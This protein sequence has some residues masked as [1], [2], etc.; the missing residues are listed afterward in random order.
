MRLPL[1][2]TTGVHDPQEVPNMNRELVSSQ[3]AAHAALADAA[4]RKSGYLAF[5]ARCG[6]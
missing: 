4:Y 6:E 3:K 1:E 2:L 5:F